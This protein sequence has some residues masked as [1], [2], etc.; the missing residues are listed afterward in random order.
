MIDVASQRGDLEIIKYLLEQIDP[1]KK[2]EIILKN[3]CAVFQIII[4]CTPNDRRCHV[5]NFLFQELSPAQRKEAGNVLSR[6][7][8]FDGFIDKILKDV[9]QFINFF[10]VIYYAPQR[11]ELIEKFINSK[12][13]NLLSATK[14][15]DASYK[16]QLGLFIVEMMRLTC[17]SVDACLKILS[18]DKKESGAIV[19]PGDDPVVDA[20]LENL[21]KES[22]AVLLDGDEA[23]RKKIVKSV[24]KCVAAYI[25]RNKNNVMNAINV[26][27][28]GLDSEKL[29]PEKSDLPK[30][31]PEILLKIAEQYLEAFKITPKDLNLEDSDANKKLC[32]EIVFCV[33]K[34]LEGGNLT[35]GSASSLYVRKR[36][37]AAEV[38]GVK[39]DMSQLNPSQAVSSPKLDSSRCA[40]EYIPEGVSP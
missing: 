19:L 33:N 18:E 14:K 24:M 4:Y 21:S 13:D 17:R 30:L 28:F 27:I 10:I 12:Y 36:L 7:A 1:E 16:D 26:G 8:D 22:G 25:L 5:L 38:K 32:R 31:P 39:S 3:E 2:Q 9:E 40:G 34:V 23:V 6:S 11:A 35:A 29:D 20:C 15:F 37:E